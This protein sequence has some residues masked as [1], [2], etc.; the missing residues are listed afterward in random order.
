MPIAKL[1]RRALASLP[2]VTKP[3]IFYDRDLKGFGLKKM[4]SGKMA[5]I[6]EYRPGAG[7][8]SVAKRR[9][10]IGTTH[11]HTPETAR[12][13]ASE[14]L[15]RVRLG[16]DPV[17]QRA[18]AR[19]AE[20]V[21]EL[22]T[23][24]MDEKIRPK[25]KPRSAVL[26]DGYIKNHI[27]PAL[28]RRQANGVTRADVVKLHRAVGEKH[29]ATAN[30]LLTVINAAYRYASKAGLLPEDFRSPARGIEKFR[31]QS[32]ERYLATAELL[33]LGEAIREAETVG[34]PWEPQD[35]S[36]PNAK[37]A[38][39]RPE[40]RCT[41]IGLHA[42]AALRL[43]L[44]TGARVREIL[45]LRWEH[46][47]LER[48]L[49]LLPDSKTG[50]KTIV[51]G[52]PAFAVLEAIPR[53][54]DYVIAGNDPD[55]PRADLQRPWALIAKRAQLSG[56]RLHDLRHSFASIGVGEGM[57][58]PIIG[59]LLGHANAST[60]Q[61][62]AHLAVDPLRR[63]S[64]SIGNTIAAAMG[65]PNGRGSSDADIAAKFAAQ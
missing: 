31:E 11:M 30:R 47:D 36:K 1:G 55:S 13:T 61:R 52:G 5:W 8:R 18:Q 16:E 32:R 15:A 64:D 37:H 59:K 60:T 41:V 50:K 23:L 35:L 22:L 2:A 17:Q 12:K 20:T 43:L 34:I 38:P 14:L 21:S 7:G 44:F 54:G 28:G 26:F 58:L 63:A 53:L 29:L 24:Y 46:V 3:T 33:R 62:Y 57:G 42:A 51:L 4:P 56:V 40:N 48:G 45:D 6:I 49:L 10:V 9:M 39:K 65:E 19:R 27:E 25:R